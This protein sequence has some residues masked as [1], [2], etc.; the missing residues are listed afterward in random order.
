MP[1]YTVIILYAEWSSSV[2]SVRPRDQ[3]KIIGTIIIIELFME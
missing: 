3:Y 1:Y 2:V